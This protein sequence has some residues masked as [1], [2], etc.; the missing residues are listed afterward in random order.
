MADAKM[1][2]LERVKARLAR[3]PQAV[4]DAAFVELTRQTNSLAD[5]IRQT[6]PVDTGAL[7]STIRVTP[8]RRPLSLRIVAGG[9]ATTDKIRTRVKD[10]DFLTALLSGTA[11]AGAYDYARAVEFGHL[12]KNGSVVPARPYF[13]PIY[14]WKKKSLKR[15]VGAAGRKAAK[16][17]FEG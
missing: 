17:I 11:N 8:G 16:K 3:I 7:K 5:K 12:S 15:A 4:Q 6:V 1:S 9:W 2:G 10:S 13:F 14:R